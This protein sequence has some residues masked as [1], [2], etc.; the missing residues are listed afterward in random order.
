MFLRVLM[1]A[2]SWYIVMVMWILTLVPDNADG[3]VMFYNIGV[4]GMGTLYLIKTPFLVAMFM[5]SLIFDRYDDRQI[6]YF[7]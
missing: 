4:Q 7:Q 1:N 6:D 2:F 5:L 3:E